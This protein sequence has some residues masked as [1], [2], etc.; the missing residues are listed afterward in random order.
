MYQNHLHSYFYHRAFGIGTPLHN[1]AELGKLD[2]V[3][4]LLGRG[5]DPLIPDARGMLAV[6]R[7]EQNGHTDVVERL[8][9]LS[10]PPS[11]PRHYFTDGRRVPGY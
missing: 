4:F 9:P 1:A 3:D 10:V 7:A 6:E 2:L 5:A 11:I 8:R